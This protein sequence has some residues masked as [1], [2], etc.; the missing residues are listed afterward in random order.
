MQTRQADMRRSL[1]GINCNSPN[2]GS[3]Y[4]VEI[5]KLLIIQKTNFQRGNQ[6]LKFNQSVHLQSFAS[7][8]PFVLGDLCGFACDTTHHLPQEY[9]DTNILEWI[10][11]QMLTQD[12][13]API[14]VLSG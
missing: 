9:Q 4:L 7:L 3:T 14:C 10:Q 1:L 2:W 5:F 13:D 12:E 11:I 6:F 8:D